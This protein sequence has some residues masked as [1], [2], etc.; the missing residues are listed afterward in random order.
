MPMAGPAV[1]PR[2]VRCGDLEVVAFIV[3]VVLGAVATVVVITEEE[4]V[5]MELSLAVSVDVVPRSPEFGAEAERQRQAD[6]P[7]WGALKHGI[8]RGAV[9]HGVEFDGGGSAVVNFSTRAVDLGRLT[10]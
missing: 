6:N 2:V 8:E 7:Q 4:V 5:V 1:N 3:S 9:F 10:F